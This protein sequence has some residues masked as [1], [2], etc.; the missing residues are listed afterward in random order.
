MPSPALRPASITRIGWQSESGSSTQCACRV[1]APGHRALRRARAPAARRCEGRAL[2]A[3]PWT[4]TSWSRGSKS[5][6]GAPC[7]C[8]PGPPPPHTLTR[9]APLSKKHTRIGGEQRRGGWGGERTQRRGRAPRPGR[10]GGQVE[11][12]KRGRPGARDRL[13]LLRHP[14]DARTHRLLRTRCSAPHTRLAYF[15]GAGR[16]HTRGCCKDLFAPQLACRGMLLAA[17]SMPVVCSGRRIPH[18]CL[19][20]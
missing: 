19:P 9:P 8:P 16:R 2:Q 17:K 3:E 11:A 5:R 6:A 7:V 12:L 10:G 15:G 18:I 14:P 20:P 4:E 1:A 13:L